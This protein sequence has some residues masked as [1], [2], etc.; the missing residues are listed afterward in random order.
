MRIL[1]KIPVPQGNL[2][3]FSWIIFLPQFSP[4]QCY[5]SLIVSR[6]P[7][8]LSEAFLELYDF[9]VIALESGK[10]KQQINF[11]TKKWL[12]KGILPQ[13]LT[14]ICRVA[15]VSAISLLRASCSSFQ[16]FSCLSQK[17]LASSLQED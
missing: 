7:L 4:F 11:R 12:V 13:E 3:N 16:R 8:S 5:Y 2:L 15:N 10:E 17:N 9:S 1:K 6:D 14:C